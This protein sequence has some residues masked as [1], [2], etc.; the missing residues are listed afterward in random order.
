MED[1]KPSKLVVLLVL[2]L[3]LIAFGFA[4]AA[5]GRRSTG[6]MVPDNYDKTTYCVDD[7]NIA[8]GAL[9]PAGSHAWAI[10]LFIVSWLTF[11]IAEACLIAGVARNA[12]I[13]GIC[14]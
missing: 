13:E 8:I 12:K 7:S 10:I 5:E 6:H 11:L 4:V 2:V 1:G 9:K 14:V 3:D